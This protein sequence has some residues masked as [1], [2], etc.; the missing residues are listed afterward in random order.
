MGSNFDLKFFEDKL[1]NNGFDIKPKK[2]DIDKTLFKDIK[3]N[4]SYYLFD[5]IL[6]IIFIYT[7]KIHKKTIVRNCR[8]FYRKRPFKTLFIFSNVNEAILVIFPK[9][10]DGEARILHI[11]DKLY[12]T[13]QEALNTLKY[14]D[15][16]EEFSKLIENY[17]PYEKVREEFFEGYRQRYQKLLSLLK[18][19][20]F[21][22][23]QSNEYAQRF[24]GRLMFLYFLQ[25]KGWLANDK[26]FIN[27]IKDYKELNEV[28]YNGL[29]NPNNKMNLP[30]LNGSL[31]DREE[32]ITDD[33]VNKISTEMTEFFKEA[34]SFFNHYN[35]TVDES[36]PLEIE[37]SI[38]PYLLGTVFEN[39]LPENERGNKGTFYTPPAEISFIIRRAISNYL[40]LNGFDT[41][42]EIKDNKLEDGIDKYISQLSKSKNFAELDKFKDVLLKATVVDPAVGSGGFIVYY[43]DEVVRIINNAEIEVMNEITPPKI[44]K[45]KIINN[46]YG[47]DIENEAVEIARLRVW[48]SYVIDEERPRPL[49]NLDLN[50]ITVKDSLKK[51]PTQPNIESELFEYDKLKDLKRLYFHESNP[52]KKKAL[53]EEIKKLKTKIYNLGDDE[54]IENNF[55]GKFNIVIMNPPYV[56]QEL[57]PKTDKEYYTKT[58][59]LNKTSDLYSYFFIRALDLLAPRGIVSVI[60]SDKWLEADYGI[61]LQE[62]LQKKLIAI[63]GQKMRSFGA[64]INTVI[65][66][67][68]NEDLETSINF[69]YLESYSNYK[70]VRNTF[71]ERNNLKP[72]KWFYL[73]APKIFMEKI[74]PKLT[75]KLKD[76]AEVKRGFTTGANDFFYMINVSSQYD[77]DYSANPKKFQELGITARNEKE[78]REQGLIYIENEAGERFVIN[79]SDTSPILRS[80]KELDT[81][82]I[83]KLRKLC[84]YT[85]NP[86]EFTKKYIEWGERQPVHIKGRNEIVIGYNNVPTVKGRKKW[87]SLNKL[88]PTN[89]ILTTLIRDRFFNP[90]SN[91]A[92]ICDASLYT[93]KSKYKDIIYYLNSTIF[94]MTME[95]YLRRLGGGGGV[96]EIKVD[97]YEN[98]PVPDLDKLD[99]SGLDFSFDRKVKKYFE[100]VKMED[101]RKLDKEILKR[102]GLEDISLDEFYNEFIELVDDRLVKADRP[103]KRGEEVVNE[104]ID[105]DEGNDK[106]N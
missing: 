10:A 74:Y 56:R 61:S 99:L 90:Y 62:K 70:I 78:L 86:G 23:K 87:Y 63:Y 60:S 91:K 21:S 20:G 92:I 13:D 66:V 3:I 65:S 48:L 11:E 51:I 54:Y 27:N 82:S 6:K 76:F 89:I 15:K 84:L 71:I 17:L 37:V 79:E 30:Y 81:Y 64:D 47:F 67:F 7:D 2:V 83:N 94:Y 31:F 69:T 16:S 12:H 53:K 19:Y 24:L 95:L 34:R 5:G 46:I 8:D 102:M 26:N 32:Y 40:A 88:E 57:I 97:D 42:D 77:L 55:Q 22:E 101:R 49:P 96:G 4:D 75:H 106:D 100:E 73:R 1:K 33:F 14:S 28:F 85:E 80:I 59:K 38:D 43:I 41:K 103:L 72:G 68:T 29:N 104:E 25:K 50:I 44:I 18:N 35:F 93:L 45:E 58:Y 98:M 105:E 36:T 52:Q 9:G 39:M